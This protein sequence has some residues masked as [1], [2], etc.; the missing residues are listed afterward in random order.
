MSAMA[1]SPH[2]VMYPRPISDFQSLAGA[3]GEFLPCDELVLVTTMPRGGLQICRTLHVGEGTVRRYAV[4][5]HLRDQIAW[6]ALQQGVVVPRDADDEKPE[7]GSGLTPVLAVRI[8]GPV[9]EGYPGV[10]TVLH[11]AGRD[12]EAFEPDRAASHIRSAFDKYIRR[13]PSTATRNPRQF[14]FCDGK[15]LLPNADLSGLDPVLAQSIEQTLTAFAADAGDESR[16]KR[17]SLADSTGN[18]W[19]VQFVRY[20]AYPALVPSAGGGP[21]IF[22]SLHPLFR[23]WERLAPDAFASDTEVSRLAA[24]VPFMVRHFRR[25]PTLEEVASSVHLSQ[26]HFHRRFSEVFGLTPKELLYDLQLHEA[27]RL[28]TDPRQALAEI[29]RHCGFSHQSH[30]TSRFKQGT[31]LTPTR[32]RRVTKA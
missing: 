19:P 30:F 29:A 12:A 18:C 15:S 7:F 13:H 24:A 32:W 2:E 6:R 8:E 4:E 10:L 16:M 11:R 26:Y 23:D 20:A 28:L 3:V 17:F 21:V 9:F 25:G 1:L 27:K 31:G 5:S 14:I 22:V